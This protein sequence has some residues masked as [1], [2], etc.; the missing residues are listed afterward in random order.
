[1][2]RSPV[3]LAPN[4]V[5][6]MNFQRRATIAIDFTTHARKI[7]VSRHKGFDKHPPHPTICAPRNTA[8]PTSPSAWL[9]ANQSKPLSV[10]RPRHAIPSPTPSTPAG[11]AARIPSP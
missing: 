8:P 10:P 3:T 11:D 7:T 5:I 1:M 9:S 2:Q 6:Y 4:L